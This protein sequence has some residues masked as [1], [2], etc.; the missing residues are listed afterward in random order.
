MEAWPLKWRLTVRLQ[1]SEQ[2]GITARTESETSG[3][4]S[5]A[6]KQTHTNMVDLEALLPRRR[7]IAEP[8]NFRKEHGNTTKERLALLWIN[9]THTTQPDPKGQH[10]GNKLCCLYVHLIIWWNWHFTLCPHPQAHNPSLI[11][12]KTSEKSHWKHIP[13]NARASV[14]KRAKVIKSKTRQRDCY[15]QEEP[16]ETWLLN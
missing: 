3:T 16:Q 13:Q 4:K 5:H 11:M 6:W 12:R 14:F 1:Q 8:S 15:N 9:L 2:R 7:S 10:H